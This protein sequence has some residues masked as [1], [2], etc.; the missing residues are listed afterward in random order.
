MNEHKIDHIEKALNATLTGQQ[1]MSLLSDEDV[2][3]VGGRGSG[4]TFV[5]C[6]KL[7]LSDGNPL[8]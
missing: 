7:A 5:H 1:R 2:F 4:R 3:C 8:I 6:I